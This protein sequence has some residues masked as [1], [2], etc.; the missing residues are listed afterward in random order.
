MAN[1]DLIV[2]GGSAGGIEALRQ[3]CAGLPANL[4]ASVLI[5][6]H[7]GSNAGELLPNV[8]TRSGPLPARHPVDGEAIKKHQIYIAPPDFHMIVERGRI[9]L[10]Q[11]A[12]ENHN[13]P[14]IDPTF[15][16]AAQAFGRRVI[17]VV[18]TGL[19]DDG[20]SGLMVIRAHGGV[21][22]VQDPSTALFPSMPENALERVPD[23]VV[24]S[25]PEMAGVLAELVKEEVP[26]NSGRKE[27]PL[28]QSETG[29][30][31]LN[32]SEIDNE[33]H[34]GNPSQFAC[35]EC[36]GVLWEINQEGFLRFRCR[37]G[38]AYT[39]Q[40][41][42][43]EQ[44]QAIEAALWSALRALEENVS[45]YRRMANHAG[46]RHH[47]E[48]RRAYEDRARNAESN[49]RTLRDF[50]VHV[51]VAETNGPRDVAAD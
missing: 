39:T 24:A 9:R 17:G 21:A 26:E 46:S 23:A 36:G 16:S 1:R 43:A 49:A 10:V 13:R 30:A 7:T 41:L 48:S 29:F 38:H 25:L 34:P 51:N 37:V 44:R 20:T 50:L 40:Y 3:L 11:G 35:P 15:R 42:Q 45:L 6:L 12:R 33:I 14:A 8:L 22:V 4:N 27:D 19:L 31:K 18:L 2:I 47:D 32:M 28:T 5:V